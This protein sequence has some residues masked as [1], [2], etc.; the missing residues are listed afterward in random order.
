MSSRRDSASARL[1]S[2]DLAAQQESAGA[3]DE[4]FLPCRRELKEAIEVRVFDEAGEPHPDVEVAVIKSE[5][6][7][8]RQKTDAQG[9]TRFDGLQPGSYQLSLL[10]I[11][12]DV[13]E[14]IGEAGLGDKRK[15]SGDA[16]WSA[17]PA[18]NGKTDVEVEEGDCLAS[19]AFEYGWLPESLW[20][21]EENAELKAK[22]KSMYI[23]N[24]GD[25]VRI[26]AV[27]RKMLQVATGN[28]Y[29]LKRKGVPEML[30]VRFLDFCNEPRAGVSYVLSLES[31]DGEPIPDRKG[32]TDSAGFVI[33]PIPPNAIW[34]QI[35]LM[36]GDE[37]EVEE[38]DLG[39]INPIDKTSGV[40]ARLNNLCY[41]CGEE[42]GEM[43]EATRAALQQFQNDYK[44]PVTG[45]IDEATQQKLEEIYLS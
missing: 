22:R 25:V 24:P 7:M 11:D 31:A 15:S 35:I 19:I 23:L 26:P 13:W 6:E 12:E 4:P 8:L 36:E 32:T 27:R 14:K 21:H 1:Q 20:K 18:A 17:P 16:S 37:Q 34:G 3:P 30:R 43:N 38:L 28:R 42:T 10:A 9:H 41:F 40:Q 45:K 29:D 5:S 44:L 33:A 39:Y 2:A